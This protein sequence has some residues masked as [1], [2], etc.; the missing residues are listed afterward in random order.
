MKKIFAV[1]GGAAILAGCGQM[2]Q[3]AQEFREQIPGA[4]M[5]QMKTFEVDRPYREVSRTFQTKAPECLNV[6]VRTVEQGGG[7]YS[8]ILTTYKPTVVVGDKRTE[9]HLQRHFQGNVIIP[10]KEPEGGLYSLVV[11]A[12]P[13]D[14]N[15]TKVDIYGPTRGLDAVIKAVT[16]WATGQNVGCPDMTK[17]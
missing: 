14:R 8:N 13:L 4:F 9:L 12:A 16:G 15:R 11:D 2:P 3:T 6:S 7:S 5:G 1:L 10:G 17:N